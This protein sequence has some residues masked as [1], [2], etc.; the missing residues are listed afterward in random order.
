[1]NIEISGKTIEMDKYGYLLN[2]NDW[3]NEVRDAL[4]NMH[5][6]EEHKHVCEDTRG[7]INYFRDYY[8][9]NKIQ[10]SIR[11][12]ALTLGQDHRQKIIKHEVDINYLYKIFPHGP[13]RIL[14]KLA[15]LQNPV[16]LNSFK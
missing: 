3:N 7:L 1:M 9:K 2:H 10:P 16:Y 14:F 15:G 12:I 5:E 8:Q 11:K 13:V 4:I 6:V